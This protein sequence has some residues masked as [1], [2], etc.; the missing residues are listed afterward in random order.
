MTLSN[1]DR[2]QRIASGTA[3]APSALQLLASSGT[4]AVLY[5][6]GDL[7]GL[8]ESTP[9]WTHVLSDHGM[10]LYV[11]GDASWTRGSRCDS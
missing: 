10:Q 1:F 3:A 4:T 6:R 11:K 2:Y 5:P 8:L 7:T 9:G